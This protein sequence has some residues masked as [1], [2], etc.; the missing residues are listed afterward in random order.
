MNPI[1]LTHKFIDMNRGRGLTT[2]L[3]K[4]LPNEK[5]AIITMSQ[6]SSKALKSRIAEERPDI[7]I[8]DIEFLTYAPN[9]GWRDKLLFRDMHVYFDNDVLNDI[10]I[11]HVSAINGVYGKRAA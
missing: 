8:D 11:H 9:S 6:A 7:R 4:S 3:I 10:L 2:E 5:C 1:D